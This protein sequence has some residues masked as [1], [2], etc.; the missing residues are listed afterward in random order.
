MV[1]GF[2]RRMAQWG[3][4]FYAW[5]T[6]PKSQGSVESFPNE[7]EFEP[8]NPVSALLRARS[9]CPISDFMSKDQGDG[10]LGHPRAY[11]PTDVA[12]GSGGSLASRVRGSGRPEPSGSSTPARPA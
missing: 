3:E 5:K 7:V 11:S 9:L 6:L 12:G 2:M 10:A 4:G 8:K 1:K